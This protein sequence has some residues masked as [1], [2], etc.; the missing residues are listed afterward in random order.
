MEFAEAL[1]RLGF[2]AEQDRPSR[3]ART[4]VSRPNPYLTYWVHAYPDGSALFTWEYAIAE[5]L[6]HRGITL[7]D[8]E[9]LNLF[10]YPQ[11]DDRGPQDAGW[12]VSTTDQA[13]GLL[14]GLSLT[15][16]DG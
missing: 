9:V 10:M 6:S 2:R 11:R 7:G 4:Y 12:L 16:P 5:F 8:G 3:G 15:D 1:S 14:R 13:D